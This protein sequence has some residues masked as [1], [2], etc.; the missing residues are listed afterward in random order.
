MTALE[1]FDYGTPKNPGGCH[2][3]LYQPLLN[4]FLL[5][6]DDIEYARDIALIASN[7]YLLVLVNLVTAENYCD[8]LIDNLCCENWGLSQTQI[9]AIYMTSY[10]ENIL[11]CDLLVE[12]QHSPDEIQEEKQYL[13][14]CHHYLDIIRRLSNKIVYGFRIKNFMTHV[15]DFEVPALYPIL[16]IKKQI[17]S[18]LYLC[19]DIQSTRISIENIIATETQRIVSF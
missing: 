5:T 4:R 6:C 15:I 19:K 9:P 12:Q 2:I 1:I 16:N 18:E 14:I 11:S 17:I 8:N 7:R 13:Q 10:A 3:G